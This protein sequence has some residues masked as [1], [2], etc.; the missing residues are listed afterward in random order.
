MNWMPNRKLQLM[1]DLNGNKHSGIVS[2]EVR[3]PH[4]L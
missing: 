4:Y 1:F 2:V 3:A